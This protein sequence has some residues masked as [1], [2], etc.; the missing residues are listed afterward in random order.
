MSSD[1]MILCGLTNAP[2]A[3]PDTMLGELCGRLGGCC[4]CLSVDRTSRVLFMNFAAMTLRNGGNVLIP[5]YPTVSTA[6]VES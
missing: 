5:C 2:S 1:V 4:P 6:G 3:N